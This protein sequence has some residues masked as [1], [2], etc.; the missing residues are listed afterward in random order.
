MKPGLTPKTPNNYSIKTKF[1]LTSKRA[2][3]RTHAFTLCSERQSSYLNIRSPR[4]TYSE[5][6]MAQA[7]S[8]KQTDREI[9]KSSQDESCMQI[10]LLTVSFPLHSPLHH[11]RD[12]ETDR[13]RQR[14]RE[15]QRDSEWN[16]RIVSSHNR[17]DWRG[18]Y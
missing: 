11:N 6:T 16:E 7:H 1:I 4:H 2:H 5:R 9:S 10:V 15:R 12:T 8:R 14:G 13:E 17:V 3:T 18:P